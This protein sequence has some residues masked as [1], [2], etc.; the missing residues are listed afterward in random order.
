MSVWMWDVFML[1]S[2][3]FFAV[4]KYDNLAREKL[5]SKSG[6]M[7]TEGYRI[8]EALLVFWVSPIFFLLHSEMLFP[9]MYKNIAVISN[10]TRIL[11]F[12]RIGMVPTCSLYSTI[13]LQQVITIFFM[14]GVA[15]THCLTSIINGC[16]A[17]Q[18]WSNW[19][20]LVLRVYTFNELW[21][22]ALIGWICATLYLKSRQPRSRSCGIFCV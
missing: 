13:N 9:N 4:L 1:Y 22:I 14:G 5:R 8:L 20:P 18:I 21:S 11:T 17:L 12:F 7:V 16:V 3:K 15:R 10:K 19:P 2:V 6:I